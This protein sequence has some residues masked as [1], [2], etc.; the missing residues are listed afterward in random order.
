MI[1]LDD[2]L[3]GI[4]LLGLDTAPV[5]YFVEAH[6]H[7]DARVTAVF[8]RIS[9]GVLQASTSVITLSEVLVQPLLQGQA[10]LA[11]QYR[12]LLLHSANFQ[13][14][15]IDAPLAEQ[16]ADLRARYRLRTPDALQIAAALATGCQ[17]FLINDIALRRVTE[18]RVLV[19][20]D[21][22]L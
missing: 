9:D 6:P 3:S 21:L 4:R 17:A 7:Y 1:K 16:A 18:L 12:D 22:E 14:L 13:M 5:I 19:L 11:Q 15:P 2:A 8:Q 20:D 10:V